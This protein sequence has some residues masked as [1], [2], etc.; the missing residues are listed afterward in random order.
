MKRSTKIAIRIILVLIIVCGIIVI[1]QWDNIEAIYIS[2]THS[3]EEIQVMI[4]NNTESRKEVVT[5]LD[6]RELTDAEKA[7][8]KNGV[9]SSSDA[10]NKILE[11]E[12]SLPTNATN[13][14]DGS[15]T[16]T[17]SDPTRDYSAELANLI[18][19]VYVLEASFSGALD[20]LVSNAIAEYKALPIEKH[21][22]TSK[23]DIGIKYLGAATSMEA[24]CDQQLATILRQ[25][26]SV[27]IASGGNMELLDQIKSAY[28][29]EKILKKDYYLSMYS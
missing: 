17:A 25:I 26:E 4:D 22:E 11:P 28:K 27:L 5:N 9:L 24:S 15:D 18:G 1:Y 7:A 20:N 13:A 14:S 21:T 6:V 10:L 8:I 2:K 3:R 16:A 12:K 29:N 23:W 19:Q